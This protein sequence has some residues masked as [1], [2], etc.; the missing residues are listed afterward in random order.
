L[1]EHE[2][3]IDHPRFKEIYGKMK[4]FETQVEAF[5]LDK[6]QSGNVIDALKEHN[7]KLAEAIEKSMSKVANTVVAKQDSDS[8][9]NEIV[10]INTSINDLREQRKQSFKDADWDRADNISELIDEAKSKLVDLKR[11]KASK[12]TVKDEK[13]NIPANVDMPEMDSSSKKIIDTWVKDN[14]WYIDDPLMQGAALQYEATKIKDAS[15]ASKPLVE[16]LTDIKNTVEGRF[17][18]SK[19]GNGASGVD[20]SNV[21]GT[22]GAT[23]VTLSAEEV[24]VANALGIS[25]KDYAQQVVFINKE[26]EELNNGLIRRF[27]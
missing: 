21:S 5:K 2:P 16:R 3:P 10:N 8:L 14:K 24:A 23:E 22:S 15:W 18:V 7:T 25:P 27:K 11:Q 17:G 1:A 4:A 12:I 20:M 13:I 9:N 26:K 19:K 6:E